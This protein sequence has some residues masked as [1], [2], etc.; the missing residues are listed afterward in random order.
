MSTYWKNGKNS[1]VIHDLRIEHEGRVAQIDHLILTRTLDCHV[2]E[3]KGFNSQVR[4]SEAGE[5]EVRT[6]FGW[7]GILSP[8]E[9]NRRHIDVLQGFI[10][11]HNLAPKRFG[12]SL[13]LRFHNWVLVS[14]RCHF[15]R[16][17]SDWNKVVKMD[18]F[19]KSFGESV[20]KSDF[21]DTLASIFKLVSGATV[22]GL[23]QSLVAA[24]KPHVCDFAAR[25]GIAPLTEQTSPREQGAVL[26]A[27]RCC[28]KCSAVIDAQVVRYCRTNRK[29][30]QGQILCRT[31]Q[32]TASIAKCA[33]CGAAVDQK[34][35]A[36]CR[37]NSKRL[38]KKVL[39]RPCQSK[40]VAVQP[41]TP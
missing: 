37:L 34:V 12:T 9:Q 28:D 11:D 40:I 30:F 4:V 22:N 10:R 27:E 36:F 32:R 21:I 23:G 31:C 15:K 33:D 13:S 35:V 7:K 1:A 25:F 41:A 16:T 6:K 8:V 26:A 3:S 14:P 5:W 39:C 29:R 20:D 38:S 19:E 2:L 24:H 18:M 17:G